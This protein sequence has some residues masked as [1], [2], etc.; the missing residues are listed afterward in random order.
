MA[1]EDFV[2]LTNMIYNESWIPVEY[3]CKWIKERGFDAR[4]VLKR[5]G[6]DQELTSSAADFAMFVLQMQ[7]T[8]DSKGQIKLSKVRNTERYWKDIEYLVDEKGDKLNA[9]ARVVLSHEFQFKFDPFE[10]LRKIL[11]DQI[12]LNDPD[13]RGV[14]DHY[15]ETLAHT[16]AVGRGYL[17]RKGELEKTKPR[18]GSYAAVYE[19]ILREGFMPRGSETNATGCYKK[20]LDTVR[21]DL[22]VLGGRI[23]DQQ[24]YTDFLMN[25]VVK[26]GTVEVENGVRAVLDVYWRLCELC[27]PLLNAARIA[28]DLSQGKHPE[29][30]PSTFEDL[31]K[32]LRGHPEAAKLVECVEPALRNAEAHVA[33]SVVLEDDTPKVIAYDTRVRPAREIARIPFSQVDEKAKCLKYSLLL[34]SLYYTLVLFEYAFQIL[35]LNSLEFKLLLVALDQF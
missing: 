17:Q 25:L 15:Y 32:S 34:E 20:F 2:R 22:A 18:F 14:K 16:Y 1:S 28:I 6:L 8:A 23:L 9:A 12:P 7:Q 11:Q 33:T 30:E 21:M 3:S 10:G 24:K 26:E 35:V 31:V 4:I 5:D 29:P 13:V 27:Y 19:K